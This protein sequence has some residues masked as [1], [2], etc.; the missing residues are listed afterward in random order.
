MSES[1]KRYNKKTYSNYMF[2]VRKDSQL[3]V[4]I[5]SMIAEGHSL[6]WLL[7]E[8][9]CNH[10]S[11]PMPHRYRFIKTREPLCKPEPSTEKEKRS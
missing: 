6:N 10:L 9:I 3:E 8:L 5:Q 1:A 4:K 7:T 2:R 11:V